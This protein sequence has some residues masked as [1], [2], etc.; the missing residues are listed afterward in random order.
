MPTER[1]SL[2]STASSRLDFALLMVG[3]WSL[4][5]IASLDAT[6]VAT[7]VGTIGSSLESMQL[8]S[9]IGTS[10]LLSTCAFTPL[11]GRL[12]NVAGRRPSIL[13]GGTLFGAGTILCGF[14]RNMH[15]LIAFR[16]LAGIGGGGMNVVG[17]II[18]SDRVPLRS[19]GT[20]IGFAT[21]LYALGAAIGA[22]LGG[23]L[24]DAIGWRAAFLCQAPFSIFGL[25]LIYLKAREPTS[26][27]VAM[28]S[29][30]ISARLKRIDYLGSATL[31][32][33]L[34]TFL[35]GMNF[36]TT[37]G[38]DWTNPN[39]WGFLSTS[40][41]LACLFILIEMKFAAEPVMPITM[42]QRR[43]P[44]FVSLNH[45]LLG[46]LELSVLYN[47]PL[48]F[49]AARLR[50]SADAGAH[51]LPNSVGLGIGALFVGWYM[52]KTGKYWWIQ[53]FASVCFVAPSITLAF[54]DANTPEWILYTTLVPFGFGLAITITT[55]LLSVIASVQTDEI[56]LVTAVSSLFYAVGEV[57]GVA[58]S[59]VLTQALL[60][61]NLR[62]TIVG[63]GAE[64]TIAKIL[65]STA[66]I[67]NLPAGL[68]EKATASWM[69]AL[70]VVFCCH[71]ILA[72]LLFLS[73]LPIEEHPL[74]DKAGG[75]SVG[76][77]AP[78]AEARQD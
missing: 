11:Y 44:G 36:K 45:L 34:L 65:A 58:L 31:L 68:R 13:L 14:A 52:W 9:W 71:I 50:G 26:I 28:S 74:T 77:D 63:P 17:S 67:H 38:S 15:Q 75:T 51:L 46:I 2:L 30:S 76:H 7:L 59:A 10:Y 8:S 29:A 27:L 33:T 73:V 23:W 19:R 69:S 16:A 5:F 3:V 35:V 78:D 70:H 60:T 49:T 42:L 62:A 4:M 54:W 40:L 25:F 48:Y 64:D 39:V 12:A 24:G 53:V 6:I 18:V 41:A 43:N 55:T 66:Y 1:T 61:R 22:P 21:L 20:F 57:L 72:V 37:G 32:L 56:A 47:T